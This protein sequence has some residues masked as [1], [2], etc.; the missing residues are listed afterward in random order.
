[1]GRCMIA[2]KAMGR[3]M[4]AGKAMG[5]CMIAGKAM[6]RCMIAGK[7]SMMVQ[8]VAQDSSQNV[9]MIACKTRISVIYK[10]F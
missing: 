6:G 2:G 9:S 4:I 7:A 10:L 5:R 3:C 8:Q 1:M